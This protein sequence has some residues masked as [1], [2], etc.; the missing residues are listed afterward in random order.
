MTQ[1]KGIEK[2]KA[3]EGTARRLGVL[4]YPVLKNGTR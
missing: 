4:L 3:K 1:K 2:K